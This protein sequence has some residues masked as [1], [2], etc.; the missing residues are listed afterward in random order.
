M[1]SDSKLISIVKNK[2]DQ[3]D[4]KTN[5][6]YVENIKN[7]DER[8][9]VLKELEKLKSVISKLTPESINELLEH[10]EVIQNLQL[11]KNTDL[12]LIY[13]IIS[14]VNPNDDA[15]AAN[16]E[17]STYISTH[18]DSILQSIDKLITNL[19]GITNA[20][21]KTMKTSTVN[22]TAVL[23]GFDNSILKAMKNST[24]S[25]TNVLRGITNEDLTNMKTSTV[26]NTAVL[27]GFDN[28]ILKS[29]KSSTENNT[30]VL[31]GFTNDVLNDMKTSTVNNTNVLRG[32]SNEDLTNL[33]N[34][35]PTGTDMNKINQTI[36]GETT[37]AAGNSK[38]TS[39]MS[40]GKNLID[41]VDRLNN[42]TSNLGDSDEIPNVQ[43]LY[44][45]ITGQDTVANAKTDLNN[46]GAN[47]TKN[48]ITKTT[49]LSY[50]SDGKILTIND[51]S[52][53][54]INN[55]NPITF[56]N[57]GMKITNNTNYL[58]LN[59]NQ[60]T[61]KLEKM[62]KEHIF[63]N[64]KEEI[65]DTYDNVAIYDRKSSLITAQTVTAKFQELDTSP[66]KLM[67]D[68]NSLKIYNSKLNSSYDFDFNYDSNGNVTVTEGPTLNNLDSASTLGAINACTMNIPV[69]NDFVIYQDRFATDE[70][71]TPI[72]QIKRGVINYIDPDTKKQVSV[73]NRF[74]GKIENDV[75]YIGHDTEFKSFN[76]IDTSG[77]GYFNFDP[78][79][80]N[81]PGSNENFI[82]QNLVTDDSP[83]LDNKQQYVSLNFYYSLS[84]IHNQVNSGVRQYVSEYSTYKV[85][86]F[87]ILDDFK[88][89]SFPC[90]L[91]FINTNFAKCV[92]L[93]FKNDYKINTSLN[94]FVLP[95][96]YIRKLLNINL[97][98]NTSNFIGFI[99]NLDLEE[100]TFIQNDS[101]PGTELSFTSV[102]NIARF[103]NDLRS[104]KVEDYIK[105]YGMNKWRMNDGF[106]CHSMFNGT[107]SYNFYGYSVFKSRS[108]E[109]LKKIDILP[110]DSN[111]S[112]IIDFSL[113][114]MTSEPLNAICYT[115]FQGF[116][117]NGRI[118]VPKI[119]ITSY[120]GYGMFQYALISE[121]TNLNDIDVSNAT[122]LSHMFYNCINMDKIDIGKWDLSNVT[123]Y[124]YFIDQCINLTSLTIN[125]KFVDLTGIPE[126]DLTSFYN[127]SGQTSYTISSTIDLKLK[128]SEGTKYTPKCDVYQ[129]IPDGASFKYKLFQT[130]NTYIITEI[131]KA[132]GF[133]NDENSRILTLTIP[134]HFA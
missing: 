49:P 68:K 79:K 110:K 111:G 90:D 122:D 38:M 96:N 18:S 54:N 34:S 15:T 2:I 4:A 67:S 109:Y 11:P 81:T 88:N 114:N 8:K 118:K 19:D 78:T 37:I 71:L 98:R 20:D 25:N 45:V 59:G 28:S 64:V 17:I 6:L 16:T 9:I 107:G 33:K 32:I 113:W 43:D 100:V 14:G 89:F 127:N 47:A 76:D 130:N 116:M 112:D 72:S 128:F 119:K 102:T 60:I 7:K 70:D 129:K 35:V 105:T 133:V 55:V 22:N 95:R 62:S 134:A 121:V 115:A 30:T 124:S 13:E 103:F 5:V 57:N 132:E 41:S 108:P 97:N 42:L 40:S 120:N 85:K 1:N 74:K 91:D 126:D 93:I 83:E 69:V 75:I 92:G 123:K 56:D 86:D 63:N 125:A 65:E 44:T 58:N 46:Y 87:S 66:F 36:T 82:M 99:K 10:I 29:M 53:V 77:V 84:Q 27:D 61:L 52:S 31:H 117:Y 24:E 51:T 12:K 101:S 48:L 23:D 50:D 104:L 94:G 3:L 73:P 131:T 106:E 39:F 80:I 26:N 21:L